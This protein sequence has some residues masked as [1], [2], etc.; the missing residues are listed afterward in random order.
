MTEQALRK[1]NTR[2]PYIVIKKDICD[3]SPV[4]AGTRIRVIDIAIE[5]EIL[6]RSP[7]EIIS[8]HPHVSLYHIHDA[9]SYY[10]ENRE[11]F[12]NKIKM[13]QDLVGRLKGKFPSKMN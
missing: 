13:D 2:H 1:Q 3:G 6:G 11:E 10:Y 5:Y 7:D 8:M 9:L 4:I 12:D